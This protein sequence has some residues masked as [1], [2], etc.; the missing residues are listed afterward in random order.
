MTTDA[1]VWAG[2]DGGYVTTFGLNAS[3]SRDI[4]SRTTQEDNLSWPTQSQDNTVT[5]AR[6][7]FTIPPKFGIRQRMPAGRRE[8]PDLPSPNAVITSSHPR[9]I[10]WCDAMI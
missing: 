5:S 9:R 2:H 10:I 4:M 7:S 6:P 8:K 1:V 3:P